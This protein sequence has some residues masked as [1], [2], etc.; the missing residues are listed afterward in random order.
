M[1]PLYYDDSIVLTGFIKV[2][3][4]L[5]FYDPVFETFSTYDFKNLIESNDILKPIDPMPINKN[6]I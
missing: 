6:D 4:F 5:N 2:Y 1:T 3:V